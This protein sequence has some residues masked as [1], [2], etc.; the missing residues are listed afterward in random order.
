MVT[1]LKAFFGY[2]SRDRVQELLDALD[3][4][5]PGGWLVQQH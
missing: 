5:E 1:A 2:K 4:D 3:T